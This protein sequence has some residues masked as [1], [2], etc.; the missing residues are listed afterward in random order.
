MFFFVYQN[1]A[2]ALI[3]D[4]EEATIQD[5]LLWNE[6]SRSPL[7]E[8]TQ[9]FSKSVDQRMILEVF[10]LHS[11]CVLYSHYLYSR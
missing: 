9:Y 5:F 2:N 6:Q 11:R 4:S 10:R 3:D 1:L 7:G 8:P